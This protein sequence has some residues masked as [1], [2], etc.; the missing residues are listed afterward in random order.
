MSRVSA[1]IA[2]LSF[3][4]IAPGAAQAP[5]NQLTPRQVREGWILL[6]DG[7]T[8]FGWKPRGDTRW[9]V[10]E[11]ALTATGGRGMLSTTTEFTDYIL[12]VEA[13]VDE[14]A[15][16]GVFLRCPPEGEIT[17]FSAYEVNLYDAQPEWPTGSIH[18]VAKS[19]RRVRSAGRWTTMEMRAEGDRLVVRVNGQETVNTRDATRNRGTI[20]LQCFGE[21]T[22]RFRNIRLRPLSLQSLFNGKDLSGWKAIP[23]RPSVYSVTPEGTLNV[24][25][26]PGDLQSESIWGDFA[27]QLDIFVNGTNLNSGV[28]FRGDAGRFWSGYESQIRNQWRDEDRTKPVDFGTGGVYNLQP[29]RRVVASDREWFTMT[30]LAHGNHIATWVNGI[31]VADFTDTRAESDNARRGSRTRPGIV[32]LQGHDPT[33]DIS[34]RNLQIIEMPTRRDT[35]RSPSRTRRSFRG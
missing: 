10:E 13:W 19:R 21:G 12:S 17:P 15:N 7:E 24:K 20:A 35:G 34:F 26:G 9:R 28:F 14:K 1:L 16:S 2:L 23:D 8:D 3:L 5:Q 30:I 33:T 32:S 27:F 29:A 4:L 31:Q 25:N 18:S 22:V 11:G 6:F